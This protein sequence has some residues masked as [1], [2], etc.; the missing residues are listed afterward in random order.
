MDR[1]GV[2]R[3]AHVAC[4]ADAKRDEG[5]HPE[6][7]CVSFARERVDAMRENG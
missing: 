7:K 4:E 6:R 2:V 3:R 5:L 1:E